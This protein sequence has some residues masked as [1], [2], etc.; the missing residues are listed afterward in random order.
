MP[1]SDKLAVMNESQNVVSEH[2][3]RLEN[4]QTRWSLLRQAGQSESSLVDARNTLVLR[5]AGPIR[6]YVMAMVRDNDDADELAQDAV[7][8]L[9]KGDFAGADPNRGRFRDLLRT[10]L[11]NMVRNHWKRQKVRKAS[12]LEF[13]ISEDSDD[14]QDPWLETWR[15]SLLDFAWAELKQIENDSD[16]RFPFTVL[17]VRTENPDATS[18]ELA[19]KYSQTLGKPI[20]ADTYRQQL[21]RARQVFSESLLRELR[22][23]L[24]D[25]TPERVHDEVV[26]LGLYEWLKD[27]LPS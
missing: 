23:G 8:R 15:N 14:E 12:T 18:S 9:L 26:A 17:T 16:N 20:K 27:D 6:T 2:L 22:D 19:E 10:A 21:K 11:R 7:M 3:S 13:D 5:Y 1:N 4:V 25:P 24:D